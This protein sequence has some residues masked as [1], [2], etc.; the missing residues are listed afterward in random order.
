MMQINQDD[1]HSHDVYASYKQFITYLLQMKSR[2]AEMNK[3]LRSVL[4]KEFL[5]GRNLS[6][7]RDA[8]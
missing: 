1:I 3:K 4:K 8:E 6:D 5:F 2:I 7:K